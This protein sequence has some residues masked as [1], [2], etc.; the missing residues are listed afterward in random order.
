MLYM[1]GR[2]KRQASNTSNRPPLHTHTNQNLPLTHNSTSFCLSGFLI[3]EISLLEL[4]FFSA[5][6]YTLLSTTNILTNIW[7]LSRGE[8]A[9]RGVNEGNTRLFTYLPMDHPQSD[10]S[11]SICGVLKEYIRRLLRE[12]IVKHRAERAA[13]SK[14]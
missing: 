8:R 10:F 12:Q 4:L 9:D 7:K 6:A 1:T 13:V 2:P 11:L 5:H 14:G 3:R